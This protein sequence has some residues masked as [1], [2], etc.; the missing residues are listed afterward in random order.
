VHAAQLL[1]DRVLRAVLLLRQ[2]LDPL[3]ISERSLP[4]SLV[5]YLRFCSVMVY[6]LLNGTRILP[7]RSDRRSLAQSANELNSKMKIAKKL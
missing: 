6:N 1:C 2:A 5:M 3:D 7:L 4:I